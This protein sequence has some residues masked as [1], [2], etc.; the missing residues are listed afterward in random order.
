MAQHCITYGI[1]EKCI[2]NFRTENQ[3]LR[4]HNLR[5]QGVDVRIKIDVKDIGFEGAD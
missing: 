4:N 3:K 5:K 2:Q 1:H